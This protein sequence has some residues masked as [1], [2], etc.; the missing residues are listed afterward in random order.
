MASGEVFTIPAV[1]RTNSSYEIGFVCDS[2]YHVNSVNFHN[3][4]GF[5][6]WEVLKAGLEEAEQDLFIYNYAVGLD[7]G[8]FLGSFFVCNIL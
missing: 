7:I 2:S 5:V 1:F 8:D 3:R 6:S 4:D